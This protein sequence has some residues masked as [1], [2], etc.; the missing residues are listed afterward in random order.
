MKE[1]TR[2][3]TAGSTGADHRKLIR[4]VGQAVDQLTAVT[5]AAQHPAVGGAQRRD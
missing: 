5:I 2:I 4:L 3:A 1:Q